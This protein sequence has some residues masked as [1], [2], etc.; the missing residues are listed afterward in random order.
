MHSAWLITFYAK[1]GTAT[2]RGGK[3]LADDAVCVATPPGNRPAGE[4]ASANVTIA[5]AS[6]NAFVRKRGSAIISAL[7]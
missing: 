4:F 7:E 2:R 5:G 3:Q 1:P 6:Y